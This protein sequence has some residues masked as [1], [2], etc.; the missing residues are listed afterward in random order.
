MRKQQTRTHTGGSHMK[1]QNCRTVMG[2]WP[3]IGSELHK[4]D[5]SLG[6]EEFG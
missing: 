3:V 5:L 1:M 4:T 2:R 6:L